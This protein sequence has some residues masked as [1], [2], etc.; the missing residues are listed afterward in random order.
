V[1]TPLYVESPTMPHQEPL[2]RLA[3][4]G[5]TLP[6]PLH[7]QLVSLAMGVASVLLGVVYLTDPP[8]PRS[9]ALPV[10][11]VEYLTPAMAWCMVCAGAW[12]ILAAVARAG[13][14]SAHGVAAVVHVTYC[15]GLVATFVEL[16]PFRISVVSILSV[17]AWIAH[18]GACIDY[19]KRGWK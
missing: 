12:V 18:G 15:A 9:P 11:T 4:P 8:R 16:Q 17:F 10:A 14:S 7:V 19:W 13:R 2:T 6:V 1:P 3:P 5:L